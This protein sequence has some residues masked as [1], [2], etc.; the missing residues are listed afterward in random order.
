MD[1]L[2]NSAIRSREGQ[3]LIISKP[4]KNESSSNLLP[5]VLV[6]EPPLEFKYYRGKLSQK[7]QFSTPWDSPLPLDYFLSTHPSNLSH[8]TCPLNANIIRLLPSPSLIVTTSAGLNQID[9]QERGISVA[10]AGSLFSEDDADIAVG[11]LIDVPRKISTG[12]RYLGGEKVGIV[13][14]GSFGQEAAK[15]LE[16]DGCNILYNSRTKSSVPYPCY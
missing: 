7:L 15:G 5:K 14:L 10:Y 4:D 16:H 8:G 13:G 9:L 2:I 11:L 6:L 3:F 1:V 12:N